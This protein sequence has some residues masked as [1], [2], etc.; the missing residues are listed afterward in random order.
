MRACKSSSLFSSPRQQGLQYGIV[1]RRMDDSLICVHCTES[2]YW[3]LVAEMSSWRDQY[4]AYIGDC[5]EAN[6][7]ATCSKNVPCWAREPLPAST[8]PTTCDYCNCVQIVSIPGADV[9]KCWV[10]C[11]PGKENIARQEYSAMRTRRT[12]P[13]VIPATTPLAVTKRLGTTCSKNACRAGPGH[14]CLHQYSV[15]LVTD[16]VCKSHPSSFQNLGSRV[17]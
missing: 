5:H 6:W 9:S 1:L 13:K 12:P 8:F 2:L 14:R 7:V 17:P 15:P 10:E 11:P 3:L 16:R 4:R